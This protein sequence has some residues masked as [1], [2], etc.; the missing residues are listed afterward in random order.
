[1]EI[2]N[3]INLVNIDRTSLSSLQTITNLDSILTQLFN[4]LNIQTVDDLNQYALSRY[5]CLDNFYNHAINHPYD[6]T[7]NPVQSWI[8]AANGVKAQPIINEQSLHGQVGMLENSFQ[9]HYV[10][11]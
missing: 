11:G 10:L 9:I 7:S 3:Y 8:D 1:M 6:Y 4:I 5:D 2:G